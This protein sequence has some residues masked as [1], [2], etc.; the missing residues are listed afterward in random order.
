MEKSF[1]DSLASL[2]I[3]LNSKQL[4]DFERYYQSLIT[5]NKK[6]NLTSI[7]EKNEIYSKH[8]VDSLWLSKV[9]KLNNQKILDVGSGAGFP[10]IPLKIVYPNLEITIIDSLN[11]RI[12]FLKNLADELSITVELIHG[13]IE[14]FKRKD[15]YDI[16]TARAV[17][18]LDILSEFCLPFT[19][20]GGLFLPMKGSSVKKEL[21][22]SYEVIK[23]MG[24]DIDQ[25][26]NYS[27]DDYTR[28]IPVITKS[29]STPKGYP[30]SLSRIK[31]QP[32]KL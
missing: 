2:G 25:I 29:R 9:T 11:K 15:Y 31:K 7:T 14:D 1:K 3:T 26:Y 27:Y 4:K 30:R 18:S 13:R 10:S 22:A 12:S 6:V 20:I 23:F 16:V 5:W 32:V 21:E 24:G 8:F 28:A 19:R 17:A